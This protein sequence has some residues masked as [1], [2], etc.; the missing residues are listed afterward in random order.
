[1][2]FIGGTAQAFSPNNRVDL[3][4]GQGSDT[5]FDIM[6]NLD[7]LFNNAIG[8]DPDGPGASLP[9]DQ[10]NGECPI[11]GPPFTSQENWDHDVAVSYF[12]IGSGNGKNMLKGLGQPGFQRIDYARSSSATSGASDA[13]LRF[14]AYAKDALAPVNFQGSFLANCDVDRTGGPTG[15]FHEYDDSGP[16]GVVANDGSWPDGPDAGTCPD[17]TV[18]TSVTNVTT[19][20][21][22]DIYVNCGGVSSVNGVPGMQWTDLDPSKLDGTAHPEI[23]VWTAQ[24]GSGTRASWDGSA[25]VNGN[26]ANCIPAAFKDNDLTNGE[27]V[28]FEHD[29][30]PIVKC[31][32][33]PDGAGSATVNC[34]ESGVHY[35][36]SFYY[37][38]VGAHSVSGTQPLGQGA[39]LLNLNGVPPTEANV[40]SGSY[41]FSRFVFNLYRRPDG[42]LPDPATDATLDYI[43]ERGWICRPASDPDGAGPQLG[44]GINPK[45]GNNYQ[46]DI[47]NT[48]RATG[49][50]PLT[51]AADQGGGV[52]SAG[53]CRVTTP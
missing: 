29:A 11:P 30:T 14:V 9:L 22:K 32:T 2:L 13:G 45:T 12:A 48:I 25:F 38:G 21:V 42:T 23:L 19:Q 15:L 26:S 49:F 34:P 1:M 50:V 16:L 18:A 10:L 53:H 39:D 8:C 51:F 52:V 33:D 7:R 27:R 24:A 37:Y 40:Q 17:A 4:R 6:Q 20:Q 41:T 5:T 43:G 47:E 46:E 36:Q 28:I 3:I 31:A 35:T 44:H